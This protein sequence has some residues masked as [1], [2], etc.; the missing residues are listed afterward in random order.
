MILTS[1]RTFRPSPHFSRT[2][3]LIHAECPIEQTLRG[4]DTE[5]QGLLMQE[6]WSRAGRPK[7]TLSIA[8]DG[9]RAA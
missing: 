5:T 3:A 4:H 6:P 2:H 1:Q 7:G 9:P 8:D